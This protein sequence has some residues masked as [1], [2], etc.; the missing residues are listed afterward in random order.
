ML[1]LTDAQEIGR[2]ECQNEKFGLIT[3]H[4]LTLEFANELLK[5]AN[6]Y[7]KYNQNASVLVVVD[8]YDS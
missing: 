1:R 5:V 6:A 3:V 2:I 4:L 7:E 8:D